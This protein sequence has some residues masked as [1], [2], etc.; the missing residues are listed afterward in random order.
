MNLT[1]YIC[2]PLIIATSIFSLASCKEKKGEAI[3]LNIDPKSLTVSGVSSGGYMAHQFH[4]AYSDLVKGAGLIASGPFG[5]AENS[6]QTALSNCL[7]NTK[8][9]DKTNY[10]SKLKNL[11]NTD[12][13][14]LENLKKSKVW[15]YRGTNDTTVSE[16]VVKAQAEVYRALNAQVVEV[17]N[18]PSGHGV[19]TK[20][21]GINCEMTESPFINNCGFD[22]ASALL[23]YINDTPLSRSET[24]S[25]L[26]NK[27]KIIAINQAE[28]LLKNDSNTLAD[29]GYLYA[30]KSCINGEKCKLHIAFHGCQ[31]NQESIEMQF[32]ENAGYNE[33]ADQNNTVIL[34]PQ[35]TASDVPLNPKACWDWWGCTGDNYQTKNGKQMKHVYQMVLGITK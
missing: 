24:N 35:T 20:S 13:S 15:I 34:Y 5:C 29:T 14:S 22:A 25:N 27:G 33:W 1:K 19:P 21:F 6:L 16:N 11:N 17:Y 18:F 12:I 30:P 7:N 23:H 32:I 31:Q 3:K 28:Y 2:I 8:T 4:I 26:D 10:L 9:M